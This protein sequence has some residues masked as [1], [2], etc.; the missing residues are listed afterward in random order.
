MRK[1]LL[2]TL[3]FICCSLCFSQSLQN[4]FI[5]GNIADKT[6]AVMDASD[7]ER[8]WLTN[9]A[10]QFVIKNAEYL[11]EDRDLEGLALAAIL[12]LPNDYGQG[13][14]EAEKE[15]ISNQLL[16]IYDL[17]QSNTVRIAVL[18]KYLTLKNYLPVEPLTLKLNTYM[19][20]SE[21]YYTDVNLLKSIIGV[22]GYIGDNNSFTILYKCYNDNHFSAY[23]EE[24]E[25]TLISLIP[26]SMN[27]V[28]QIIHTKD[29][30][31]IS[32][33]YGLILKN[34][35]ISQNYISE[36]AENLLNESILIAG[37]TVSRKDEVVKIQLGSLKILKDN[38]CTRA[39][40]SV[41]AFFKVAK[42]EYTEGLISEE[43]FIEVIDSTGILA[44]MDSVSYLIDYL[45]E[46]NEMTENEREVS[47]AIVIA[48]INTLG[49]IGDKTAF[50]SLLAVTY[51]DYPEAI[52]SAARNALAGLKW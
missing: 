41:L 6:T 35:K 28:L 23:K 16:I 45:E 49:A 50:D 10:I 9:E 43:Q 18:S 7:K 48:V 2:R 30:N 20:S 8:L 13:K 11:G 37:N 3:L 26:A 17:V 12:S 14:T 51:I 25:Q 36:I 5:K 46:M 33:I 32:K 34:E 19:S 1:F 52:L 24:L 31:Q 21:S 47:P 42:K 15:E 27:E 40:S 39:S 38:K 29:I 4:K 22:L 44:P